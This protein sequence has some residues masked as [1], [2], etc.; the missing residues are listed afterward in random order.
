MLGK[1]Q[2]SS[3]VALSSLPRYL[4]PGQGE[5]SG[6]SDTGT[7]VREV[8]KKLRNITQKT[9]DSKYQQMF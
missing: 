3:M 8:D 5:H 9:I 6:L 1:M 2:M 7:F 4:N